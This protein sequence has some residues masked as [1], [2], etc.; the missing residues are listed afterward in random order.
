MTNSSKIH[1]TKCKSKDLNKYGSN[2]HNIQKYKCKE[3]KT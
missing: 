1:C 2:K 3:C